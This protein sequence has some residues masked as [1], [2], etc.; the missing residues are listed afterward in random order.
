[1][2]CSYK[3]AVS[4]DT[5]VICSTPRTG[6]TLLC[7]L[8]TSTGIAGTPH[9]YFRSQDIDRRAAEWGLSLGWRFT[10]YSEAVR[11]FTSSANG[12]V[13]LRV[14]WGTLDE[15]FN[16]LRPLHGN[17]DDLALLEAEFGD[18]R[19]IYLRR[20]DLI[21]QAISLF[22]AEESNYWHSTQPGVPSREVRYNYEEIEKRVAS[23]KNDDAAWVEWF[24]SVGIEPF[25]VT[26]EDLELNPID[27]TTNVLRYL[28]LEYSGEFFAPNEK[29]ADEKTEDWRER[30]LRRANAT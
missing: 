25:S 15:I 14:M 24:R 9:S 21:G 18:V 5:Y 8:L 17:I 26:Y 23:L 2:L 30:Y 22:K 28:D 10:S 4:I 20:E 1:M 12:V 13:G 3:A 19:Y 29:L 27:A 6:S 16:E 11:R 7:E